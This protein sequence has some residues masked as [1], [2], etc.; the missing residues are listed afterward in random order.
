MKISTKLFASG[1]ILII[2]GVLLSWNSIFPTPQ[3][4]TVT[5]PDDLPGIT[6]TT[7][8]WFPEMRFLPARLRDIGL[9]QVKEGSAMHIHVHVDIL[10]ASTS[11]TVPANIGINQI[12]RSMAPIHTH[13]ASGIVHIESSVVRDFTLGQFFDVWG[14]RFTKNC[15]GG[16]CNTA[17]STLTVY[18]NGTRVSGNPRTLVLKEHD[19]VAVVFDTASSTTKVP[20]TYSFPVGD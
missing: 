14:V 11:I 8:P 1:G 18:A 7:A 15:L 20:S 13:D 5:N 3:V 19:E 10:N 4:T 16:Y 9:A 6:T 12:A 2:L 17:T